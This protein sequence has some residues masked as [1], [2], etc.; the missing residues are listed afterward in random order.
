MAG[1]RKDNPAG[2]A[3]GYRGDVL[4]VLGA[5]KVAT[6]DQIRRIGAPHLAFRRAGKEIPSKRKQA[7]T[8]SRTVALAGVRGW[9][10]HFPWMSFR[11]EFG[12]HPRC[13]GVINVDVN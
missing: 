1:K 3:N 10:C 8:A 13:L 4:R 6:V 11:R 7:R 5:L 2:S 9:L 12:S